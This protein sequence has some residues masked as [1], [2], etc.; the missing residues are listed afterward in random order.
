[1]Q[2]VFQKKKVAF[3][4][5]CFV[6][7][8]IFGTLSH[9]LGHIVVAKFLNYDTVLHFSSTEWNSEI[10]ENIVKFY[11]KNQS[12]VEHRQ[13]FL[14][15]TLYYKKL[16][17]LYYDEFL[18]VLGGVILTTVVGTVSF[19]LLIYFKNKK[20][21]KIQFWSLVFLSLFW[22]RQIFNLFKGIL[23]HNL[24]KSNSLFWGDELKI[25]SYLNLYEGTLSI[26]LALIA[27]AIIAFIVFKVIPLRHR[28][29]FIIA[30]FTGSLIG[31]ILW[32]GIIG[33]FFLP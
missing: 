30:A 11:L 33:P 10:K 8:T 20:V 14:N 6:F 21:S 17:K 3:F 31:Y 23:Q 15:S 2:T 18:I 13:S 24:K 16:D 27:F 9:E 4:S 19:L 32:M 1:M 26:V 22:S 5:L 29:S 28:L 7:L 12:L 25:A